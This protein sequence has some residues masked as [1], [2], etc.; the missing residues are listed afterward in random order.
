MCAVE[1]RRGSKG[2][3]GPLGRGQGGSRPGSGCSTGGRGSP[4]R[5]LICPAPAGCEERPERSAFR[6]RTSAASPTRTTTGAS[7]RCG[8]GTSY[9]AS[10]TSRSPSRRTGFLER[11]PFAVRALQDRRSPRHGGSRM[12][13]RPADP[14][15]GKAIRCRSAG[16]RVN[17]DRAPDRGDQREKA[18]QA[19]RVNVPG[20]SSVARNSGGRSGVASARARRTPPASRSAVYTG[21]PGC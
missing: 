11:L 1:E 6:G 15:P 10:S 21:V 13:K 17:G 3:G 12:T 8:A 9:G 7:S 5:S 16:A 2:T 20:L 19:G 18:P 4:P 14:S